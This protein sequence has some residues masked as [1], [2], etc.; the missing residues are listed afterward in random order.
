ML[1][2]S[3]SITPGRAFLL[4]QRCYIFHFKFIEIVHT[5][6]LHNWYIS[7]C[8][9]FC[10]PVY[11]S[12][13]EK[14]LRCKISLIFNLILSNV[15]LKYHTICS[16]TTLWYPLNSQSYKF[17]SGFYFQK[18]KLASRRLTAI[19]RWLIVD[20]DMIVDNHWSLTIIWWLLIF[21][22]LF[23][24]KCPCHVRDVSLPI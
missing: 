7:N 2:V 14:K 19:W 22:E 13:V 4:S 18:Y 5:L 6:A 11:I 24:W 3:L 10:S 21:C 8:E 15:S 12:S 16:T 17:D 20:N 9:D 1:F 23:A